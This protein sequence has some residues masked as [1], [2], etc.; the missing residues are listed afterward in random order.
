MQHLIEILKILLIMQWSCLLLLI[1]IF[2]TG[3]YAKHVTKLSEKLLREPN[4]LEKV[5]KSYN[6]L[7]NRK[8]E[9]IISMGLIIICLL[10]IWYL[11]KLGF[12]KTGDISPNICLLLIL[13]VVPIYIMFFVLEVYFKNILDK[14][15]LG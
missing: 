13:G 12:V 3:I 9:T 8:T 10:I 11:E 2:N 1:I 6:A 4:K 14:T 5:E 7:K 15:K